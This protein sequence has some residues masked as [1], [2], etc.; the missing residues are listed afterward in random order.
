[1]RKRFPLL[2]LACALASCVRSPRPPA[3]PIEDDR[4]IVFPDFQEQDVIGIGAPGQPYELHGEVLRAV[5]IAT[6]DFLPPRDARAACWNRQEAH[7][8][9]VIRQGDLVF[10]RISED[11][12]ACGR[13]YP[14]LDSGAWYAVSTDGRIRRRVLDGQWEEPA[15]RLPEDGG[16]P[17]VQAEPGVPPSLDGVWNDPSRPWPAQWRDGGPGPL[18]SAPLVDGGTPS[19]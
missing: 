10:V 13:G 11:P 3:V 4:S 19:P 15:T 14:T 12:A 1:M 9:R 18:P 8:Y 7:R 2:V 17:K 16:T 6:N 5:M